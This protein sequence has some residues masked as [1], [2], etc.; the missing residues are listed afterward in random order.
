MLE[1][2]GYHF[3]NV[4]WSPNGNLIAGISAKI[5]FW[6]AVSGQQ[7]DSYFRLLDASTRTHSASWSPFGGRLTLPNTFLTRESR[8]HAELT[9]AD[10]RSR[11]R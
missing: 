5:A 1:D 9:G 8:L 2:R 6:D 11:L 3:E 10:R 7:V 4:Q